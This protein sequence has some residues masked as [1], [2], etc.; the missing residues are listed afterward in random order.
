MADLYRKSALEKISNPEQLDKALVVTSP[1]SW[2]AL[3]AV[4]LILVVTI[5]WSIVGRIPETLT[6][7]GYVVAGDGNVSAV[8][9]DWDG[10][11]RSVDV[12]EGEYVSEG[13]CLVR[14]NLAN[15]S[16]KEITLDI[17]GRITALPVQLSQDIKKGEPIL[18]FAPTVKETSEGKTTLRDQLVVCYVPSKAGSDMSG[19]LARGNRVHLTPAGENSQSAG[20]MMGT[21]LYVEKYDASSKHVNTVTGSEQAHSDNVSNANNGAIKAVVVLLDER[22]DGTPGNNP[23]VWSNPKGQNLTVDNGDTFTVRIIVKEVRPIE[24]L[25]AKIGEVLGW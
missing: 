2:L 17:D 8:Y 1:L 16:P 3:V 22:Q 12:R 21:V 9:S 14:I 7:G 15:S 11:V 23:Y 20:H 24:K 4:T 19:Q 13:T 18:Y 5:V 10:R 6:L 25:F